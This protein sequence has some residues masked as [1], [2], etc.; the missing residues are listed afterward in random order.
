MSTKTRSR[1]AEAVRYER[2]RAGMTQVQLAK[3]C[4]RSKSWVK[5]IE[6][7]SRLDAGVR[8]K[9]KVPQ[10]IAQALGLPDWH[11]QQ[12][13]TDDA[14]NGVTTTKVGGVDWVERVLPGP[15]FAAAREALIADLRG[16]DVRSGASSRP[17]KR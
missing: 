7:A 16:F 17:A 13:L 9:G 1:F 5:G 3:A 6:N 14:V 12:A 4:G 15:G 8:A 2:E 10:R 11:F